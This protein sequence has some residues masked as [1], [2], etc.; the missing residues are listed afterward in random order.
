MAC[1]ICEMK[2]AV[3]SR[4]VFDGENWIGMPVTGQPGW[5][6]MAARRHFNWTWEMTDDEATAF[7]PAVRRMSNAVREVTGCDRV[8]VLGLGENTLHCHFLLI[9]RDQ[10]LGEEVRASI[11]DSA[12]RSNVGAEDA[13]QAEAHL[14]EACIS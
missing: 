12:G 1:S 11:R 6:M 14:R 4:L 9:P 5:V 13:E 7:G 2:L 8:Y 3:G 10:V